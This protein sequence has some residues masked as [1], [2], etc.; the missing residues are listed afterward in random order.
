MTETIRGGGETP[1]RTAVITALCALGFVG[2][3]LTVPLVFSAEIRA[4]GDWYAVFTGWAALSSLVCLLGMWHM[5]RWG[6]YLYALFAAAN[7]LVMLYAG[8]WRLPDL[9]VPAVFAGV[10]FTQVS[11]MR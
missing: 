5:Y 1:R 11:R 2:A 9:V 10:A 4:V 8:G 3:A 6:V 7:Q